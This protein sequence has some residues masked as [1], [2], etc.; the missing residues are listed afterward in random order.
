LK[1]HARK[2]RADSVEH[3]FYNPFIVKTLKFYNLFVVKSSME[4]LR[5]AAIRSRVENVGDTLPDS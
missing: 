4:H 5:A 2:L 1:L 3:F